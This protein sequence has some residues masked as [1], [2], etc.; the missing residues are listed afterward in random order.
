MRNNKYNSQPEASAP[1]NPSTQPD[2]DLVMCAVMVRALIAAGPEDDYNSGRTPPLTYFAINLHN[3]L[4]HVGSGFDG[5]T[6]KAFDA[7]CCRIIRKIEATHHAIV[8]PLKG[9]TEM[10]TGHEEVLVLIGGSQHD[11]FIWFIPVLRDG[12]GHFIGLGEIVS[13]G[14]L[15]DGELL[16]EQYLSQNATTAS[17]HQSWNYIPGNN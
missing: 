5:S 1:E 14:D 15:H 17:S 2:P 7:C 11:Q 12:K 8:F 9:G 6:K 10:W 3:L 4:A 16:I 13:A